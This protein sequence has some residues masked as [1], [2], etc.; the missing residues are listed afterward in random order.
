MEKR[1]LSFCILVLLGAS[2][3]G[4][5][6][7][8]GTLADKEDVVRFM[9]LMHLRAT[10]EQ[11]MEGVKQSA[12]TGAEAAFKQDIPDAS[13]EQLKKVDGLT[14]AIFGDMPIN[15][16]IAAMVPIYQKHITKSDLQAIIAFYS[17]PVGQRL[18]KE[19]PAM[20]AEGMQA[21][22]T[23]MLQK[24]PAMQERLK[25]KI[26]QLANEELAKASSGKKPP[27]N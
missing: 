17:S 26:S 6:A 8:S 14:D 2:C 5:E 15:E 16:I 24:L 23:I 25:T 19:Q 21:G 12:R 13:A 10:M 27:S 4:Q 1:I 20:M 3:I 7:N 18:L 22:Q 9:D 11:L